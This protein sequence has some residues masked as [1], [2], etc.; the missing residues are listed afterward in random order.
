M[1]VAATGRSNALENMSA[2]SEAETSSGYVEKELG[3]T[4]E[5]GADSCTFWE[6]VD[7]TRTADGCRAAGEEGALTADI[8]EESVRRESC[9]WGVG[10][11]ADAVPLVA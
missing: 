8:G 2:D 3:E 9:C 7:G 4:R 1:G 5:V 6:C 10:K 11:G